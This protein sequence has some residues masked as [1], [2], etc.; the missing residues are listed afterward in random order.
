[1]VSI[2]YPCK[3]ESGN[4]DIATKGP[5]SCD[6]RVKTLSELKST[7][8]ISLTKPG[9]EPRTIEVKVGSVNPCTI[10]ALNLASRLILEKFP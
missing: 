1:L 4:I 10:T 2:G 8:K 3:N 7:Q 9:F 6:R 5:E